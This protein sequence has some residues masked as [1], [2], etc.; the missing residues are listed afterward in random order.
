M[1]YFLLLYIKIFLFYF[2]I[3]SVLHS[4]A[5]NSILKIYNNYIATQVNI[6]WQIKLK[7]RWKIWF[8]FCLLIF[9]LKYSKIKN[10]I[11]FKTTCLENNKFEVLFQMIFSFDSKK[12]F[13]KHDYASILLKKNSN[14]NVKLS[15]W[16]Y[17]VFFT[18]NFIFNFLFFRTVFIKSLL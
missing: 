6:L 11:F 3:N 13:F 16:T 18:F 17:K 10:F 9:M 12:I 15:S 8:S 4:I 7:K 5:S 2:S 1:Y 14:K